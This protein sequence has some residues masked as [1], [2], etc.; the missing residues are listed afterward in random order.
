MIIK[1]LNDVELFLKM[2]N[3]KQIEDIKIRYYDCENIIHIEK[4]PKK[5]LNSIKLKSIEFKNLL[6][7]MNIEYEILHIKMNFET[8]I[9]VPN[10]IYAKEIYKDYDKDY[11]SYSRDKTIDVSKCYQI[12]FDYMLKINKIQKKII[13]LLHI[14]SYCEN[15]IYFVWKKFYSCMKKYNKNNIHLFLALPKILNDIFGYNPFYNRL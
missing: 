3:N 9:I 15:I 14:I 8:G 6:K 12:S 2:L 5:I 11:L 1:T 13:N 7:L 10:S 4:I